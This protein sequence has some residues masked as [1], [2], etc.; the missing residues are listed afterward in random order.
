MKPIILYSLFVALTS[1]LAQPA[2]AWQQPKLEDRQAI[3]TNI[4]IAPHCP[5]MGA[6]Y[7]RVNGSSYQFRTGGH[8]R[9]MLPPGRYTVTPHRWHRTDAA[10]TLDGVGYSFALSDAFDPVL[11]VTRTLLR[12]HPDGGTPGTMGCIGILGGAATQK[13]FIQDMRAEFLA[14]GSFVLKVDLYQ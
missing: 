5:P 13:Q 7:M 2:R 14:T 9:G 1:A 4:F 10:M 11:K 6:G 3:I 12:I 8:G